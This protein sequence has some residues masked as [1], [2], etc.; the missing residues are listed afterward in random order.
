MKKSIYLFIIGYLMMFIGVLPNM[1]Y[2][3]II[4]ALFICFWSLLCII[5]GLSFGEKATDE[6]KKENISAEGFRKELA[7][8]V[9]YAVNHAKP[10]V[11]VVDI[12]AD[13]IFECAKL[14]IEK[15]LPTWKRCD[16]HPNDTNIF[17]VHVGCF[18]M[19]G[20]EINL[21]EIFNKLPK[22]E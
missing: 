6:P 14:E 21:E 12:F 15:S 7:A 13:R 19:H 10:G 1:P 16:V 5:H 2:I 22:E 11:D 4:S 9:D 17:S 3:I 8:M 20:Y 18:E